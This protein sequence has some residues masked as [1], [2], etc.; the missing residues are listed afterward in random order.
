LA[1]ASA[2]LGKIV[3]GIDDCALNGLSR[4][5]VVTA[6]VERNPTAAISVARPNLRPCHA[7][8]HEAS[9]NLLRKQRSTKALF[10]LATVRTSAQPH[11]R[12]M[13]TPE[14]K[15]PHGVDRLAHLI[16]RY[17]AFRSSVKMQVLFKYNT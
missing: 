4:A 13:N 8:T 15:T 9:S 1:N 3:V 14:R 6:V 5:S 2:K 10:I 16:H 17:N 7:T 12:L 11:S